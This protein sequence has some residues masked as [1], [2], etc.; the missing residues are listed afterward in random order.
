MFAML[1]GSFAN[2]VLD[3]IFIFPMQMGIFGV[4]F[5]TGLSP[6]ISMIIMLPHWLKKK[7]SFQ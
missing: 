1:A 3:Y 2:I 4:I 6:I 7:N 5:A